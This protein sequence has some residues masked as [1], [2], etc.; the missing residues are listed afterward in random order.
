LLVIVLSSC[1]PVPRDFH[2]PIYEG[3]ELIS[4]GCGSSGPPEVVVIQLSN[5]V[6]LKVRASSTNSNFY[7][8]TSITAPDN[9]VFQ[10]SNDSLT[11]EDNSTNQK[12]NFE[13]EFVTTNKRNYL[14]L[15]DSI[16]EITYPNLSQGL[17]DKIK[18]SRR[19]SD[20]IN[21]PTLS[22]LI[23]KTQ[24]YDVAFGGR[25]YFNSGMSYHVNSSDIKI[26]L[27]DFSV[28]L[29]NIVVNGNEIDLGKIKFVHVKYIGV[30]PL[31]C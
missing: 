8:S 10:L 29:P 7:L 26:Q 25:R 18:K 16:I 17:Q 11:I 4:R 24:S 1:A 14:G 2:K 27:E 22:K 21:V 30:D 9:V 12:W 28:Y 23:G 5:N 20:Y 13:I 31:N 15:E 3:G 19:E 6:E